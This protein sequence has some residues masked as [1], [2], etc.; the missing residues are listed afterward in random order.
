MKRI[1]IVS[2]CV[3]A[4]LAPLAAQKR[5]FTIADLY[6]LKGVSDPQY[7]PDGTKIAFVVSESDLPK[8]TSNSD[9]YLIEA[10]GTGLRR[11]TTSDK[12][13][14]HP[15]WAPDGKSML[16][17]SSRKDG[18]QIWRMPADIGEPEQL[19]HLSTGV[20]DAEWVPGGQSI[21]FTSEVFPECGADDACNQKIQKGLDEGPLQAHLADELLYRHWTEWRDGKRTHTFR[22]DVASGAIV[23]LTPGER[24]T[25]PF[26]LGG[27]PF[28]VSP[29]AKEVC[30]VSK[31]DP[32]EAVST[33]ND[34]YLVPLGGG[35]LRCITAGNPAYDGDPLYSPDGRYIA[36]R[37]QAV[38]G[39][40][41]DRFR[42]A[43]YDR[44]SGTSRILTQRFDNWVDDFV[45][46]PDSQSLLFV[47]EEKGRYPIYR[48]QLATGTIGLELPPLEAKTVRGFTLS[49]D[50][51]RLVFG[52]TSVGEPVELYAFQ[53]PGGAPERL[54]TLNQAVADEVDIRPAEELWIP[55]ADG[56]PVQTFIVKPHNFDPN[57]KYPLILN[58]HGGPQMMWADSLRGDWQVYPGAGYVVA[59]P[60]PHGS[61]G[62][63]QAYTDAISR[64]WGGLVM[65]D[66]SKVTDA[67]AGLPYVDPNLM[68]V[69][70]WSWGGYA[71][72]WLE[73]HTDRFRAAAAM[74]GVYDLRAM[75]G[76]TEELWF[77]EWDLGGVP[78]D[79]GLYEAFN[80]A[81]F[82]KNFKTPCL[83]IT[84]ERDYRVPY[85]QSLEFF[86]DLQLMKVP[87]R[88]IVFKND[89]HWPSSVKSMPFYYNAHLDWFHKYLGGDPAPYDMI[90][91]WRNQAFDEVEK[92]QP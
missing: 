61:T 88:L 27:R 15:R 89:G 13:D 36:Y 51:K 71:V 26:S 43:V 5:A 32:V 92:K 86:T 54:T 58:I 57:K 11:L 9:I 22:L 84:G 53:R 81:A 52:R 42:L 40:E 19:T 12:S 34:L 68:G 85:T 6:R 90:K 50:G 72:M 35:E 16:F 49:P 65:E 8:G 75:H 60:N 79:S 24:D 64:G 59:F 56:V 4:L 33:N 21:L 82:V 69:M 2:L 41:A 63:G 17:I 10:D 7:S 20:A 18:P 46:A 76:G 25:P 91:M 48:V 37:C 55:G 29:D 45:W 70:G 23:D 67:L 1:L 38:P 83:V 66:I 28:S 44:Q 39:F 47:A 62:F 73:G 14:D 74:M 3:L 31:R 77:P 30:V 80:P 78:W 87:S